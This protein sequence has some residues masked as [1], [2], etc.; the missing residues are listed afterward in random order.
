MSKEKGTSYL[1]CVVKSFAVKHSTEGES[2]EV[3]VIL[4]A[5][6]VDRDGD[7]VSVKG[8][9]LGPYSDNP[10]VLVNHDRLTPVARGEG[11]VKDGDK[12]TGKAIFP[13]VGEVSESDKVYKGIQHGL[14]NAVSIGFLP[15]DYSLE[16]SPDGEFVWHVT[17]SELLE[18]S[19]VTVP[20]NRAAVITQRA[21]G[22]KDA[23]KKDYQ[24]T[25]AKRQRELELLERGLL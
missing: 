6:E 14:Y 15:K 1:D 2:R 21:Q 24:D 10:V 4:T 22:K 7:I 3:E 8:L 11:L 19:F 18:F 5:E 16:E 9:D 25:K 23:L 12:I 20:S 17:E 13:P